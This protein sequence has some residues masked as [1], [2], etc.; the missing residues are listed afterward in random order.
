MSDCQCCPVETECGY[1]YKPCDCVHQ[2]KFTPVETKPE[3]SPHDDEC[4]C[5]MCEH[6]NYSKSAIDKRDNG[7]N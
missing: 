2:R 5:V 1:E 3:Q 4:W 7:N 6:I